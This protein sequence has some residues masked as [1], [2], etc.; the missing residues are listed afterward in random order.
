MFS[1]HKWGTSFKPPNNLIFWNHLCI[2]VGVWWVVCKFQLVSFTISIK[3]ILVKKQ[4]ADLNSKIISLK[5][6]CYS[7]P[8]KKCEG[9]DYRLTKPN[10]NTAKQCMIRLIK[11]KELKSMTNQEQLKLRE[12]RSC[13]TH[14]CS[15]KSKRKDEFARSYIFPRLSASLCEISSPVYSPR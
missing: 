12:C 11:Y 8:R 7:L 9:R 10:R 13:E 5:S 6:K 15:F 14:T 2:A 4:K 1:Q 3:N